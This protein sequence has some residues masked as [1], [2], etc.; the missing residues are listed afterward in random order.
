MFARL[1]KG[2]RW[3][4]PNTLEIPLNTF[5][6]R[7]HSVGRA[8]LRTAE[9]V[10]QNV[11]PPQ[12]VPGRQTIQMLLSPQ[13]DLGGYETQ[14]PEYHAALILEINDNRGVVAHWATL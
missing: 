7:D 12:N 8:C 14:G 4:H 13:N 10:R 5:V 2:L 3:G 9:L 1:V 6:R 11:L